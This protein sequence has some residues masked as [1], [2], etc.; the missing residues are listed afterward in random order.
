[1]TGIASAVGCGA[2]STD[3]SAPACWICSGPA[4]PRPWKDGTLARPLA[5][6]DLCIT[7]SRYGS[8]LS[9]WKCRRCGFIF[10]DAAELAG[11]DALYEALED[12]GYEQTQDVRAFQ[13]RWLV[14]RLRR[15][16]P[17]ARSL[18]DIGAGTGLLVAEA[19]RHGLEAVGV[20]PSR[21]LRLFARRRNGV[22][23]L[24]GVF[25]HAELTG[26]TFDLVCLVDVIE[27]V[28][29]PVA[30]LTACVNALSD[31]GVLVVVTPDAA[32][33]AAKVLGRRWWHFRVAHL[34]YFNRRTLDAA[35]ARGG[36]RAVKRFRAKW[37]FR[38]EYLAE[39]LSR[40]L[41]L[42]RLNRLA[43][44]TS[45]LRWLYRRVVPVNLHDSWTVFYQKQ[46]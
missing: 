32:S 20:E 23:L 21:S 6:A 15:R 9:L 45:P 31:D 28:A 10:A 36:A 40:Y 41:P 22:D 25:P 11:L 26:R 44:R 19:K 13:A 37:F 16:A 12:P 8:T 38:V 46:T 3:A 24:G 30:L 42:G 33:V 39:R 5:S 34:G 7:D 43:R 27:H 4:G 1:M 14:G 17:R 29:D 2:A 18:L 35:A